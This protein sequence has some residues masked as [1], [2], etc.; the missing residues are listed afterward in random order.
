MALAE[1]ELPRARTKRRDLLIEKSVE[2]GKPE[3]KERPVKLVQCLGC[4]GRF[5]GWD[6]YQVTEDHESLT[7]FPS[8]RLCRECAIGH[9]IL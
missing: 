4:G 1:R 2:Q 8:D 7:H 6:L 5:R 3:R 9:G